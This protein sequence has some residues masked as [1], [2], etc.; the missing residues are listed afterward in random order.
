M[1]EL[2]GGVFS[3]LIPTW[4]KREN[5]GRAKENPSTIISL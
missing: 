2:S 4:A 5:E 1:A 3:L